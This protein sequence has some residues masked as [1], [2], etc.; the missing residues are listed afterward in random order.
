MTESVK[1]YLGNEKR[2]KVGAIEYYDKFADRV[3]RVKDA[4][5]K[6]LQSLQAEGKSIAAYGAAAKGCTLLNYVGIGG[7][8]VDF[9]VDKNP[10]KQGK[11]MTGTHQPIYPP[12]K[13]LQAM[14]DY[15]LLLPWNFADE[16]LS[17]Q[18]LYREKGGKFIIPIPEPRIV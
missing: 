8:L 11:Y 16:I 13:I 3:E 14:P 1:S 18:K 12:E 10:H 7:D 6:M 15:V 17:Q 5:S 4:L 2:Q 9:I